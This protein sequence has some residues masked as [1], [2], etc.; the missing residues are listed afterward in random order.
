MSM[1][2]AL[3]SQP[4]AEDYVCRTGGEALLAPSHAMVPMAGGDPPQLS[5]AAIFTCLKQVTL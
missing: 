4:L 5:A 2:K 3:T 1:Q